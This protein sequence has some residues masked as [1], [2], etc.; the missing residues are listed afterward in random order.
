MLKTIKN[1]LKR[2]IKKLTKQQI[3]DKPISLGPNV[4]SVCK[5]NVRFKNLPYKYI[6]NFYEN[7]FVFSPFLFETLN[8]KDYSCANCEA[9][10]RDRLIM[11]YIEK[12]LTDKIKIK[13]LDFAPAF[14][15]GNALRN[16]SK[17]EYRSADLFMETVDDNID[18]RNMDLYQNNS[19]D[20]FICSHVLEHVDD[21]EKALSELFRITKKNGMG[22]LL[23]PILL[24]LEKS[25]EN[26]EYLESEHL[27]WKY[28]GQDDHVRMYAKADFIE[29]IE[30]AGFEVEQIGESFFGD[31]VFK[32]N[33]LDKKSILYVVKK[34]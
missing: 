7:G 29:R 15:L 25:I 3:Q 32:Q 19:F 34:K 6:L 2:V 5:R 24:G 31:E 16:H 10:D 22:I 13:L 4:C 17:V 28:F 23:V 18:I 11:L 1:R 20:F 9:S 26:R 12:Y 21:D 30:N 33:G 27:R 14:A 8:I